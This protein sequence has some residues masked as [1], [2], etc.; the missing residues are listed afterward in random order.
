MPNAPQLPLPLEAIRLGGEAG[1]LFKFSDAQD[2]SAIKGL[3]RLN[4]FV[5]PNNSG[6]SR[7]LRMLVTDKGK[8]F[9]W[10]AT[11]DDPMG[12][13]IL[14]VL[15]L[16]KDLEALGVGG[17]ST[18]DGHLGLPAIDGSEHGFSRQTIEATRDLLQLIV[19]GFPTPAIV[20]SQEAWAAHPIHQRAWDCLEAWPETPDPTRLHQERDV[21]YIPAL[22]GAR[23][24]GD[25]AGLSDIRERLLAEDLYRHQTLLEQF[26]DLNGSLSIG[27]DQLSTGYLLYEKTR[28]GLLGERRDREREAEYER[29]LGQWFFDGEDLTLIPKHSSTR[30]AVRLGTEAERELGLLGDG[31]QQLLILSN[32]AFFREAPHLFFIEEPE[33][34]LHPS[35]VRRICEF[36]LEETPHTYFVA[37][38]SN[39]LLDLVW[40]RED[41]RIFQVRKE[42]PPE[43]ADRHAVVLVERASPSKEVLDALGVRASSIFM[44]NAVIWVEG[45]T[46]HLYLRDAVSR[47]LKERGRAELREGLHYMFAH[48]AGANIANWDFGLDD[49]NQGARVIAERLTSASMVIADQDDPGEKEWRDGPLWTALDSKGRFLLTE[50]RELENELPPEVLWKVVLDY[51]GKDAQLPGSPPFTRDDYKMVLLGPFLQDAVEMNASDRRSHRRGR[52][53]ER[54]GRCLADKKAFATKALVHLQSTEAPALSALAARVATFILERNPKPGRH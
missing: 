15:R 26:S 46:D 11:A 19:G 31:L 48:Y 28:Q 8:Q 29:K 39:H 40:D 32:E 14:E 5:G 4:F 47:A 52:Y 2:G 13:T 33:L 36:L 10:R 25:A 38:H 35:M 30:L 34:F 3:G 23:R 21:V 12:Q 51:E 49:A 45:V 18:S 7:V 1:T 54:K 22:R 27:P 24:L 6:K 53:Y 17:F 44:A 42:L 16:R 43:G 9:L 37:T 41:V 50:G 20:P